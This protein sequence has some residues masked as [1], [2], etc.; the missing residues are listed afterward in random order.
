MQMAGRSIQR[1]RLTCP[2]ETTCSRAI[3]QDV[4]C[5]GAIC[6]SGAG[7]I[8]VFSNCVFMANKADNYG[9]GGAVY[10]GA[11]CTNIFG[12]LRVCRQHNVLNRN[13]GA[14]YLGGSVLNV[15]NCTFLANRS[16][17]ANYQGG[18][19][20]AG[21][22]SAMLNVTNCIFRNNYCQRLRP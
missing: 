17:T 7:F 4:K 9:Y 12:K 6:Q 21:D 11:G 22:A 2:A 3:S 13:G 5:G 14:I 10:L 18:A 8:N 15:V 20:C 16:P 19:I 1:V